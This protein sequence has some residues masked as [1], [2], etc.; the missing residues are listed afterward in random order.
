LTRVGA[1]RRGVLEVTAAD[2]ATA[3]ELQFQKEPILA[4]LIAA[5]P[6]HKLRDLRCRIGPVK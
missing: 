6:D 3:Q 5:L 1:A 2:S 4:K